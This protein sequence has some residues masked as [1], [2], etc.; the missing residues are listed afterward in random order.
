VLIDKIAKDYIQAM[1]NRDSLRIR[2]LS[3]LKSAVKYRE[4]ENREKELTDVEY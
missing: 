4:I 2:V 1:K 3:Y